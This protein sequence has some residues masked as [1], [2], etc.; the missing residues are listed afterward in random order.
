MFSS[1]RPACRAG[2]SGGWAAA[3]GQ[4][5]VGSGGWA[6]NGGRWRRPNLLD[7]APRDRVEREWVWLAVLH[8]AGDKGPVA[9][10]ALLPHAHHFAVEPLQLRGREVDVAVDDHCVRRA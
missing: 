7:E 10:L 1:N 8:A 6:A 9:G 2:G 4:R 5:R 3:D